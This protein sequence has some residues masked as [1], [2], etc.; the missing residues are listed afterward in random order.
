MLGLQTV[1]TVTK[2]YQYCSKTTSTTNV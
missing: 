2:H 1:Q